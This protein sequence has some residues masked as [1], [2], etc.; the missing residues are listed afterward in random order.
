MQV[1]IGNQ[2]SLLFICMVS[3][4]RLPLESSPTLSTQRLSLI[5]PTFSLAW[6]PSR[7][8]VNKAH[9]KILVSNSQPHTQVPPFKPSHRSHRSSDSLRMSYSSISSKPCS[10]QPTEEEGARLGKQ[11][12]RA[13]QP[14]EQ[15]SLGHCLPY[16]PTLCP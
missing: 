12:L 16:T 15:A 8:H 10:D 5:I 7:S 14:Q 13:G 4:F 9:W 11:S 3:Y 6:H 1:A 2:H